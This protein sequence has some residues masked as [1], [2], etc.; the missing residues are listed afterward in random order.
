MSLPARLWSP[1]S[2]LAQEF[3]R[4]TSALLTRCPPERYVAPSTH[5]IIEPAV[6]EAIPES[7]PEPNFSEAAADVA[8]APGV[9]PLDSSTGPASGVGSNFLVGFFSGAMN[10]F[11]APERHAA[12]QQGGAAASMVTHGVVLTAAWLVS[13][14][15]PCRGVA[16]VIGSALQR[17][18]VLGTGLVGASIQMVV[19]AQ[20]GEYVGHKL[21]QLR[22]KVLGTATAADSSSDVFDMY[23]S[24]MCVLCH[25]GFGDGSHCVAALDCGHA[26]LCWGG[27]V[28]QWAASGQRICPVCRHEGARVVA[29]VRG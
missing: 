15:A 22:G 23:L 3:A 19:G 24:D 11:F 10:S 7:L 4:S 17:V 9:E 29:R 13:R 21:G 16:D 27:C 25:E 6:G 2:V 1:S 12:E 20:L 28:D 26:C 14:S 5:G 18:P 8:E